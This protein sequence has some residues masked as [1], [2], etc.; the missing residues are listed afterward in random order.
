MGHP[1]LFKRA[2][3]ALHRRCK[4][5]VWGLMAF[6][7][8][9]GIQP[10]SLLY[11][12]NCKL[13]PYLSL[14]LDIFLAT[15]SPL[16]ITLDPPGL[17]PRILSFSSEGRHNENHSEKHRKLT[18]LITCTTALSNSMKLWVVPCRATQDKW[19][20]AESSGKTWY[21]GEDN[22]TSLQYSCLENPTNSMKRQKDMTLKDKLPR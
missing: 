11:S 13:F 2:P 9:Q 4:S 8:N 6:Y 5:L 22:A 1:L 16:W 12:L 21:T 19:V 7:V 17:V 18:K 14:N 15:L 3:V 20:T 10:L